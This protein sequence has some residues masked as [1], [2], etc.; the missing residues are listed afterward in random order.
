MNPLAQQ[1]LW[2]TVIFIGLGLQGMPELF[3]RNERAYKIVGTWVRN[4]GILIFMVPI[5]LAPLDAQPRIEGI[6]GSSFRIVGI[7]LAAL[8]IIFIAVASKHLLK[9]AGPE[10]IPRELI[11][12]GVYGK[13]RNP[14]YTGVILLT[15]GWSLIWGA[16]YS[17]FIITG[18]VIL[19]LLAL[20]KFLEEPMLTKLFGDKFL[21]YRKRVP[22]LFPLPI[23][24]VI[25]ALVII[26]I[27]FGVTGLIPLT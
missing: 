18:I 24:V 19:I 14:I 23:M 7:I 13:V 20:I 12:N 25:I 15:M 3:R 2:I 4:L 11:T 16:I 8:G 10:Q 27:A 5:V 22:M 21:E 26:M 17:F 1:I 9:V 6:L